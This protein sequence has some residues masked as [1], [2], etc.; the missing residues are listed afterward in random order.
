MIHNTSPNATFKKHGNLKLKSFSY[1]NKRHL[2]KN[3]LKDLKDIQKDL[4]ISLSKNPETALKTSFLKSISKN[5][6]FK[7]KIERNLSKYQM[8]FSE[9][10][11]KITK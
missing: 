2:S 4:I 9:K 5:C 1:T 7:E 6:N 10:K 8:T 11:K 3:S